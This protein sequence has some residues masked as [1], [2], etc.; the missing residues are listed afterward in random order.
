MSG[1]FGPDFSIVPNA[2]KF[3]AEYMKSAP[4]IS[5]SSPNLSSRIES[6]EQ[7]GTMAQATVAENGLEGMNFTTLFHLHR[8]DGNWLITAKATYAQ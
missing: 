2:G 8:V 4:P 3:I 1:H 7:T 5:E 6:I